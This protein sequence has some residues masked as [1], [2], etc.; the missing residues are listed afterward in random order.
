MYGVM[1]SEG[2]R[3]F[4]RTSAPFQVQLWSTSPNAYCGLRLVLEPSQAYSNVI[5]GDQR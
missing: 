4:Q 3:R 2:S 5:A 1:R